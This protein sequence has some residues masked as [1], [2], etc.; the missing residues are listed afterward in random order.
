VR[1]LH[2]AKE[3]LAADGLAFHDGYP[4]GKCNVEVSALTS[5]F[6]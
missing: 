4:K 3:V 6:A 5:L 2:K 1:L